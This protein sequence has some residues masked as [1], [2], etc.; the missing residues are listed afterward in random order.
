MAVD[1]SDGEELMAYEIRERLDRYQFHCSVSWAGLC[2]CAVSETL[3]EKRKIHVIYFVTLT[4][5][6]YHATL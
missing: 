4:R 1:G 2:Y 5:E 6:P 3:W